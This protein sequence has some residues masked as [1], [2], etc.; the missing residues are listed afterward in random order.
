MIQNVLFC[1]GFVIL[2]ITNNFS[3]KENLVYIF[4]RRFVTHVDANLLRFIL[5]TQC[6][7]EKEKRKENFSV[8]ISMIN[9]RY[10]C[11]LV[12]LHLFFFF[13]FGELTETYV[14]GL[15][16]KIPLNSPLFYGGCTKSWYSEAL[17]VFLQQLCLFRNSVSEDPH[18]IRIWI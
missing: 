2:L 12:Y 10:F 18:Y 17:L 4:G 13:P 16:L 8:V 1:S 3:L 15:S 6:S 5:K 7:E 11:P 14:V 9:E